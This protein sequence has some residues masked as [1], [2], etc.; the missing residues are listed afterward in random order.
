MAE[1]LTKAQKKELRKIEWQEKAKKQ[2]QSAQ[3]KKY[4]IWAAAIAF[5]ALTIGGLVWLVNS[6]AP[7]TS[8][9]INVA[10][11]SAKDITKGDPK[12]KA[13]L[14]EYADFQCPAC[15]SYNPIVTQLLSD[16]GNKIYYVYRMFPL[17][18]I[19]PNSHIAAQAAYAALKQ[20]KFFEMDQLLYTNQNDW[21]SQTD[22]RSIFIEYAKKI[23]L[24]VTKFQTEMNSNE[25]KDYVNSSENQATSEGINATPTFI[26]NGVKITN[27]ASYDDFKK[28]IEN[29]LNKK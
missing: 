14:I 7:S 9:K 21:A 29:E 25:A 2:E 27:P 23:N 16:F 15:A 28:L 24:D 11:V 22:P 17:T 20:G 5:I 13:V 8:E 26:L 10:P 19:H 1:K 12:A 6:P 3:V 4:S 18:N